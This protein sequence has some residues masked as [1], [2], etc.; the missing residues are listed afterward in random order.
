MNHDLIGY[1]AAICTTLSFVPQAWK[2]YA[3][4]DVEAISLWMYIL[5]CTGVLFW[6]VYGWLIG[7][8]PVTLANAVTLALAS[9]ILGVKIKSLKQ[10]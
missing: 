9:F 10:V 7:S 8:W 1:V 3:T 4:R 2:V 5:F 6:L